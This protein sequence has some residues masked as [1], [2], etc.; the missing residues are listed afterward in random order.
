MIRRPPR[1]TQSRSSAASDVY[2]RQTQSTWGQN[3]RKEI[4]TLRSDLVALEH[5]NKEAS[6]EITKY[7]MEEMLRVEKEFKRLLNVDAAE[8]TFL[9]QQ[10]NQLNQDKVKLQQNALILETRVHEGE[11]EVGF[12]N[13]YD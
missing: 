10:V 9:K 4:Q 5:F 8:N 3:S 7:V 2:K 13:V 1:S 11:T 6:N 12:K